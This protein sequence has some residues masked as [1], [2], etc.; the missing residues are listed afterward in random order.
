MAVLAALSSAC[1]RSSASVDSSKTRV[2]AAPACAPDS[3]HPVATPPAPG[4]WVGERSTPP[5][6]VAALVGPASPDEER[7]RI[8]RH[9]ESL[10]VREGASAIRTASDTASMKLELLPSFEG[11]RARL[12]SAGDGAS[13][14]AAAVYAITPLVLLASYEPCDGSAGEPRIRYLRRDKR[15]V[16]A[17]DLMLRREPAETPGTRR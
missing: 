2:M 11:G 6:R 3:V 13:T 14:E 5:M 16:V 8:T 17:T 1:R 15:G 10:E 12:A 4:L 7:A 9:V